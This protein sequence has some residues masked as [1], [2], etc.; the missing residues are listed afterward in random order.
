MTP[1][2]NVKKKGEWEESVPEKGV[3]HVQKR[4]KI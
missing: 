1:S 4:T 3:E 2:Q